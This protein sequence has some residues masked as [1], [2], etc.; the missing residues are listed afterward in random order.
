[1]ELLAR[2]TVFAEGCR[3]HLTKQIINKF[4][5]AANS[6]PMTYGIGLKELWEVDPSKHKPGYCEHT[7]GWPLERTQYG[8]S[9]LYHI[10]D[11]G[12]FL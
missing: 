3:G 10:E 8:G 2:C 11:S 7:V 4:N 6:Q 12:L 5:L 9:F 1:M